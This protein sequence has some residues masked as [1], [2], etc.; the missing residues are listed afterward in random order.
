MLRLGGGQVALGPKY[1]LPRPGAR[2][3]WPHRAQRLS[4]VT[5][6]GFPEPL[7]CKFAVPGGPTDPTKVRGAKLGMRVS[8]RACLPSFPFVPNCRWVQSTYCPPGAS[9]DPSSGKAGLEHWAR[10]GDHLGKA[11]CPMAQRP[12]L[13]PQCPQLPSRDFP[14][15]LQPRRWAD[16]PSGLG[17]A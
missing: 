6:V 17:R 2:E 11:R 14:R 16:W 9:H 12:H 1:S 15:H 10:V 7:I 13:W 3:P 5:A 4:S 8:G